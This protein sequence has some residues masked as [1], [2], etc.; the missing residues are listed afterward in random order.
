MAKKKEGKIWYKP[1]ARGK[2]LRLTIYAPNGEMLVQS[3]VLSHQQD[4]TR[5]YN[6]LLKVLMS[7]GTEI[8]YPK[9]KKR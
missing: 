4:V 7:P 3:E 2:K 9:K 8:V 5:N 6:A 1:A